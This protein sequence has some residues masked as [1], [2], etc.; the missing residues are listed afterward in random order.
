M[1]WIFVAIFLCVLSFAMGWYGFAWALVGFFVLIAVVGITANK[2]E[3]E[4]A[5]KRAL[6][7]RQE[8]AR[9]RAKLEEKKKIYDS[10]KQKLI[11]KY[12]QPDKTI[13]LG[14]Y[15]LTKEIMAFGMINRIW[16]L[17]RDLPM[18]DILS[19][20][21]SDDQHI[22]KG[23]VTCET[24]TNT[25]NMAKRAVVGAVISGS[26]GAVIGGATAK[27]ETI[28]KQGNDRI[29][30]NYTVIVNVNSL[31]NPIVRIPLGE[32]G[33]TV[34]EIVGLLNVIVSRRN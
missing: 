25:S 33:K 5:E 27:K 24:K 8:E 29:I 4:A 19:C 32:D 16:L 26:T 20:S 10:S 21:F 2:Q 6:R 31:S 13:V 30:H 23:E 1:F 22:K 3:K 17:G 15:D 34:N 18:G 28:V 12:G 9:Q 14:E 7:R 11:D